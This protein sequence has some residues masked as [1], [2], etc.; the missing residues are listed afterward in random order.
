V[1]T[2]AAVCACVCCDNRVAQCVRACVRVTHPFRPHVHALPTHPRAQVRV[3]DSH[4]KWDGLKR[5]ATDKKEK[6]KEKDERMTRE[7]EATKARCV[8]A[9]T[10]ALSLTHTRTVSL[11]CPSRTPGWRRGGARG[12]WRGGRRRRGAG[13]GPGCRRTARRSDIDH[14]IP[15]E[16][17]GPTCAGNLEVLC[18]RHH[19]L[20]H[21]S[22]WQVVQRGGEALSRANEVAARA[23]TQPCCA[24]QRRRG[25][26]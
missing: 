7:K 6:E 1:H 4:I 23:V 17:G 13:G 10:D 25:W 16:E 22:P 24:E 11:L 21:A 26:V 14:T 2:P 18:R 20:K 15:F 19:T 12:G 3:L 8:R 9:H 5:P